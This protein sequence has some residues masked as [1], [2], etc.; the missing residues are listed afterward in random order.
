MAELGDGEEGH[1]LRS[2]LLQVE[3]RDEVVQKNAELHTGE[4]GSG[5]V[6]RAASEGQERWLPRWVHHF[7]LVA[8]WIELGG[9]LKVGGIMVRFPNRA[10][11]FPSFR[12]YVS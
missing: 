10:H 4:F 9:V 11:C 12:H 5:T 3:L 2:A 8:P 1:L 6:A 7:L